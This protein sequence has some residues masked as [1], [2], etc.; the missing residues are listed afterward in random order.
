MRHVEEVWAG[1]S[2]AHTGF[3]D[4]LPFLITSTESLEALNRYRQRAGLGPSPMNRFRPNIV[5]EGAGPFGE[6]SISALQVPW[7]N[8]R[9]ELVRPCSRCIITDID[10][11]SGERERVTETS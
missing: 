6:D 3:S 8:G 7:S 11:A 10:Q 1:S 4:M 5:I 2:G 9:L